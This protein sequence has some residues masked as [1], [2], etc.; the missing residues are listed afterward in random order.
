MTT[1]DH[2]I[3]D[4]PIDAQFTIQKSVEDLY[5]LVEE[6]HLDADGDLMRSLHALKE[7]TASKEVV[8]TVLGEFTSGKSTF[9]NSL[10]RIDLLRTGILP[11]NAV[12]TYIS[13]GPAPRC[14]V[15]LKDG[16]SLIVDAEM[17]ADY[18]SEGPRSGE[19]A[20]VRLQLPSPLLAEGLVV[21]DTPGVNVNVESHESMTANAIKEANACVYLIDL[22]VPGSKTTTDYLR[23][24]QATIG[25][26]FF[27]L[28]RADILTPEEQE[29]AS[30]Y[31]REVLTEECGIV[32]PRLVLLSSTLAR[33]AD[34]NSWNR[35]FEEFECELSNFMRNE[36]LLIIANEIGRLASIVS[37]NAQRLLCS[38]RSLA[39]Q[40]LAR[41][42]KTRL[43]DSTEI[44][45]TLK[46][47]LTSQLG[48]YEASLLDGLTI[49][50]RKVVTETY[51][52]LIEG[53]DNCDSKGVSDRSAR[54][55][56]DVFARK[57][58]RSVF[59]PASRR[60][61]E[62]ISVNLRRDREKAHFSI[63]CRLS[64]LLSEV[65]LLDDRAFFFCSQSY[66]LAAFGGIAGLIVALMR[67]SR[68]S[69]DVAVFSLLPFNAT[70]VLL[71][72]VASGTFAGLIF[73][74]ILWNRRMPAWRQ[75]LFSVFL[76]AA[77]QMPDPAQVGWLL[78]RVN[79][80]FRPARGSR[81]G[82]FRSWF[83]PSK[84]DLKR[85]L[86]A[87]SVVA[88][89]SF[90]TNSTLKAN[91][92]ITQ[93]YQSL[94]QAVL[95]AIEITVK[96]YDRIIGNLIRAQRPVAKALERRLTE[97]TSASLACNGIQED[98]VRATRA[99]RLSLGGYEGSLPAHVAVSGP[100]N[101]DV[102]ETVSPIANELDAPNQD[103][104][105]AH[106]ISLTTIPWCIGAAAAIVMFL[107]AFLMDPPA[108]FFLYRGEV[109]AETGHSSAAIGNYDQAIQLG[110]LSPDL[111]AMRGNEHK[112]MG[113]NDQAIRDF[114]SAISL[115]GQFADAF[116]D[117][118][119]LFARKGD[120]R[121]A[122]QDY[123]RAIQIRA[124]IFLDAENN[125]KASY[126][127]IGLSTYQSPGLPLSQAERDKQD[128]IAIQSALS[129]EGYVAFG[130][131][132]D[133]PG[134]SSDPT[135]RVQ[136]VSCLTKRE[137]CPNM[138]VF[139]GARP[140]WSE[141]FSD[142]L[143]KRFPGLPSGLF[144]VV[145][146]PEEM[147]PGLFL[148]DISPRVVPDIDADYRVVLEYKWDRT[149]LSRSLNS[150]IQVVNP[151]IGTGYMTIHCC[152]VESAQ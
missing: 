81:D 47:E 41:H 56:L 86:R 84:A 135:L 103:S 101:P 141:A 102:A 92:Y 111:F 87:R 105:S 20:R 95:V 65:A 23:R 15:T 70:G 93:T 50:L 58:F 125:R 51:D 80:S 113:D 138:F 44:V 35:R 149:G 132:I 148:L 10:L 140:V 104:G 2:A 83:I 32:D 97:L 11:I 21:V 142:D 33:T 89:D 24:I 107:M 150:S 124:G 144:I 121:S 54:L 19:V 130:D 69:S 25:K 120:F 40:E 68:K 100:S 122:I 67:L 137:G 53:I 31:V 57:P 134:R 78:S 131:I 5:R 46:A 91:V 39:E 90:A 129:S 72:Y 29:E 27:V 30:E 13:Y 42:Y 36:R 74:R 88:C 38:K 73:A 22:R 146:R 17:V 114:T 52:S 115:N 66:L 127:Q 110:L 136:F 8:L 26:F 37:A 75:L 43:P 16:R 139:A 49:H 61:S 151:A 9:I 28:N 112:K 116:N 119:M 60:L 145:R 108:T 48:A 6:F 71:L 147:P 45:R 34:N 1:Q 77:R 98:L 128:Y 14:E 12:C 62:Y 82:I 133:I 118:G 63:K 59:P 126:A 152:P 3:S 106:G 117:R 4:T 123:D 55:A 85:E 18:S 143:V 96:R 64:H 99:I 109:E 79:F 94:L 76:I 7:R